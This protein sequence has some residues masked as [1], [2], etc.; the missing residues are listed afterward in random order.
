VGG[1]AWGPAKGEQRTAEGVMTQV[2]LV[3]TR[4]P[5]QLLAKQGRRWTLHS[6]QGRLNKQKTTKHINSPTVA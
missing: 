5:G 2:A 3:A 4:Y 1:E 6:N